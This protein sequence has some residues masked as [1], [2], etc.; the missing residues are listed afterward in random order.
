MLLAGRTT[1][2]QKARRTRVQGGA[3]FTRAAAGTCL[4]MFENQWQGQVDFAGSEHFAPKSMRAA[5]FS[6]AYCVSRLRRSIWSWI[7][8]RS[9]ALGGS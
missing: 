3:D 7:S 8:C 2:R 9:L 4:A 1:D 5:P 6:F